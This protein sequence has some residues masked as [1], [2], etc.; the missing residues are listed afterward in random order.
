MSFTVPGGFKHPSD[1]E[2]PAGAFAFSARWQRTTFALV[3]DSFTHVLVEAER[4][5]FG[6]I[7]D[8]TVEGQVERLLAAGLKVSMVC[9]GSDIRLPSAHAVREPD[10]HF[11][12]AE[13]AQLAALERVVVR[14]RRALEN[15][16]LPVFVST[17]DLLLDVPWGTWLPVIVE[18]DRWSARNEPLGGRRPIVAHA[19]TK[20]I[21]KG[22]GLID[23]MLRRL[24]Q[25]GLVSYRRVSGAPFEQMPAIIGGA[26]IVLDQF[27]TGDYGVAACEAMAAGRLVVSHVSD[28]SREH[29]RTVTG[30]EL[31]I[32]E[33][34]ASTLESVLRD[35]V[36]RPD[37]Y[38]ERARSGIEFAATVH[39]GR[40]SAA[41]LSDFLLSR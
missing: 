12:D 16:R 33:S 31:P 11:R 19:P 41:V 35:I 7:L 39:D 15:L 2:V 18:V 9:H 23:Q 36:A 13:P 24:D 28:H 37:A 8:E 22:S 27:R 10:S 21:A 30:L 34:T 6:A 26:D 32:V 4:R 3:R 1:L 40:R 14:N 17:P 5:P 25:D 38:R 29:V 20:A